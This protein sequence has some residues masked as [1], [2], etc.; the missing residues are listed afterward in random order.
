MGREKVEHYALKS[1]P[2]AIFPGQNAAPFSQAKT[3]RLAATRRFLFPRVCVH[4]ALPLCHPTSARSG[5]LGMICRALQGS[6]CP[7]GPTPLAS[8]GRHAIGPGGNR[9]VAVSLVTLV[10]LL[11]QQRKDLQVSAGVSLPWDPCCSTRCQSPAVVEQ[12]AALRA[13]ICTAMRPGWHV[14]P[15]QPPQ[16]LALPAPLCRNHLRGKERLERMIQGRKLGNCR[17]NPCRCRNDCLSYLVPARTHTPWQA[18]AALF[19]PGH[20]AV[21]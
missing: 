6:A 14:S 17:T 1:R 12:L 18:M 5:S 10:I 21:L 4:W 8:H 15:R 3:P 9:M 16:N 7:G 2:Q 13:R 19:S 11:G 20:Q